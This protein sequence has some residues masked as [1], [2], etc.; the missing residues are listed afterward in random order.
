MN[1]VP[2]VQEKTL[3]TFVQ[4]KAPHK[5]VL[6]VE[7]ARQTGKTTLVEHVL[8]AVK[9]KSV[10]INFERRPALLSKIDSCADFSD[11]TSLLED[12]CGFD[13]SANHVLFIDESQESM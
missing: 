7:G 3:R 2:R 8:S 12:A 13:P 11:F 6:L 9:R 4:E 5:D 10:A 1:Y